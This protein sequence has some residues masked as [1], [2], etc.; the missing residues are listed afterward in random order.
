LHCKLRRMALTVE[1]MFYGV[2]CHSTLQT[3]IW[4]A[5]GDA[6]LVTVQKPTVT[7]TQL[8]QVWYGLTEAADFQEVKFTEHS[9]WAQRVFKQRN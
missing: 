6:G 2:W 8:G 5:A 9:S 1:Q 3:D 7:R 4:Y